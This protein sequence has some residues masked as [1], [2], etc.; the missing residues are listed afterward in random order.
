VALETI[1]VPAREIVLECVLECL[2]LWGEVDLVMLFMGLFSIPFS[3]M[4]LASS[5]VEYF[6]FSSRWIS[7]IMATL[8]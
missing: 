2:F 4:S 7:W 8:G 1:L 3:V 6:G 5:L